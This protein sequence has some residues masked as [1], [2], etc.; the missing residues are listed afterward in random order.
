MGNILGQSVEI[1]EVSPRDG[2][3]NESTVLPTPVKLDLINRAL[4]AGVRA[5]EVTSFVNPKLVP[6]MADADE[7]SALLPARDDV[8]FIGLVLNQRG[9]QR[10]ANAQLGDINCVVVATETFNKRNQGVSVAQTL[11]DLEAISRLAADAEIGF[12]VT[13]A[14]SFGCPFEGEVSVA[15]VTELASRLLS[16]SPRELALADTIGAGAPGEVRAKISAVRR[17]AGD[18]PLRC[19]FHNT[20]NTGIANA[21]AAIEAGVARIDS[22]IGGIGGCPFAP[23]ATGNIATED[24]VYMLERMDIETGLD[25]ATLIETAHWLGNQLGSAPPGM[26]Q[27]AGMFPPA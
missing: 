5:L 12:G 14:A 8:R 2:I 24:L 1:I 20:R 3:Q 10:A 23:A 7:L 15:R 26:L 11:T 4:R 25:I 22:S 9:F 16:L 19:H 27:R 17:I 13:I 6:Q 21:L 18:I